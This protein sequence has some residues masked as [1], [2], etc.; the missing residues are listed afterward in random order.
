MEC[1]HIYI[2]ALYIYIIYRTCVCVLG[3]A[4]VSV[5]TEKVLKFQEPSRAKQSKL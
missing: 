2:T 5:S 3:I 4:D 1:I